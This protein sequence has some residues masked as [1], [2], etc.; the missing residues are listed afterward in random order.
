MIK[1]RL[2]GLV[3]NFDKHDKSGINFKDPVWE[4]ISYYGVAT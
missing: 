1:I 2:C 4:Q 3:S